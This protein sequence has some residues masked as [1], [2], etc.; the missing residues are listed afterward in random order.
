MHNADP[1]DRRNESAM[2]VHS[3]SVVDHRYILERSLT[4]ILLAIRAALPWRHSV[5]LLQCQ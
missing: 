4:L 5:L 2:L 1:H 3:S